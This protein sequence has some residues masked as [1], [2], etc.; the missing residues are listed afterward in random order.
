[1]V[2]VVPGYCLLEAVSFCF[3]CFVIFQGREEEGDDLFSLLTPREDET[4]IHWHTPPH[5]RD[6]RVGVGGG[7]KWVNVINTVVCRGGPVLRTRC[8]SPYGRNSCATAHTHRHLTFVGKVPQVSCRKENIDRDE[9]LLFFFF[10][11]P[12]R[13][14]NNI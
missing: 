6:G 14:Y 9:K 10:F 3:S 7:R 8:S 2:S 13:W 11:L 12:G 4:C 1:M 5:A